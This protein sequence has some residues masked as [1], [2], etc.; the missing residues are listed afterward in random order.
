MLHSKTMSRLKAYL[1]GRHSRC[2]LRLDDRSVSRKHAEV[3]LLTD[4]RFYLTDRNS[5]CGT[6][7]LEDGN[8]K[9]VRQAFIA[10]TQSVRL[11]YKEI[12][13]ANFNALQAKNPQGSGVLI[14]EADSPAPNILPKPILKNH[15]V[16]RN[17]ETGE[18]V[19]R[20]RK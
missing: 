13:A 6:F 7:V 8:W 2:D 20:S 1:I 19:I 4:G 9:K 5:T 12:R 10:P 16:K 3:M 14:N 11:G 17:P 18:V 15:A